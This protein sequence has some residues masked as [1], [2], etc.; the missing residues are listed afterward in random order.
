MKKQSGFTYLTILFAI[1]IA[2]MILAN[3]SINWSQ[4][5]QREKERE[6]IFIGNQFRQAIALYYERTPGALKRY[7]AKL[8]ELLSDDRYNPQ[9]HYLRRL[10]RDPVTN[11]QQWGFVTAP[12]GG[13]M[14]VH[15]LSNAEPLKSANFD[16]LDRGFSGAR[17][18]SDWVFAY[19]PQALLLPQQS[20]H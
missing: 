10:Y 3:T 12:D 9:Q 6:L 19:V 13:I 15:S 8:D 14:G 11:S 7:P 1:A 17:K 2:G 16:Y 18:Y 20:K 5:R 4:E